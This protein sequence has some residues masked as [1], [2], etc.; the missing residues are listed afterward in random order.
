MLNSSRCNVNGIEGHEEAKVHSYFVLLSGYNFTVCYALSNTSR[1]TANENTALAG[2]NTKSLA[3]KTFD[4]E[5]G[6]GVV[7]RRVD[8]MGPRRYSGGDRSGR[9]HDSK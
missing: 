2:R 6:C 5:V 9:L 1:F 7:M 4:I 3:R 8:H